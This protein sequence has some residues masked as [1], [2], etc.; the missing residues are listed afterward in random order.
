MHREKLDGRAKMAELIEL[1]YG[2]VSGWT[3]G[4]VYGGGRARWRHLAKMIMR[5][6]YELVCHQ[7]KGGDAACSQI[8]PTFGNV[9][10][11]KA[12]HNL[13]CIVRMRAHGIYRSSLLT[14]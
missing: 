11:I 4:I 2:M 14:D 12:R 7:Q 5:G 8:R 9:V 10:T 3:E 13:I 6:D 1:P